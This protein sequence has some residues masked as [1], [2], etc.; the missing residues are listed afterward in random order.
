MIKKLNSIL[1]SAGKAILNLF[2][3]AAVLWLILGYYGLAKKMDTNFI[4]TADVVDWFGLCIVVVVVLSLFRQ[5][6]KAVQPVT[7]VKE[8]PPV[9]IQMMAG[10][11]N[12]LTSTSLGDKAE[13]A[14]HRHGDGWT[15]SVDSNEWVS[16][17]NEQFFYGDFP[18]ECMD[19]FFDYINS[20]EIDEKTLKKIS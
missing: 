7:A 1:S 15:F 5:P 20:H 6:A 12:Y 18:E 2:I 10:V 13:Y 14:L 16:G 11:E 17:G 19:K 3:R 4:T 8:E 9:I